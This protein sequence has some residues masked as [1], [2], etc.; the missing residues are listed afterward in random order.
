MTTFQILI[1]IAIAF[2]VYKSTR[3]LLKKEISI[4]LFII[5]AS[6]WGVVAVVDIFPFVIERAANYLGIGRGV[7][8]VIYTSIFVIVYILFRI[9]VRLNKIEKNISAM[10]RTIAIHNARKKD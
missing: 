9:Y 2:V 3:R 6:I 7:D 5:W 8:L 10:V 1:L 4:W